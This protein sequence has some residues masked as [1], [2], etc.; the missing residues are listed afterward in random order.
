MTPLLSR[1]KKQY[2]VKRSP[3]YKLST[4][5][6]LAALLSTDVAYISAPVYSGLITQYNIFKCKQTLRFITEPRGDLRLIHKRLLKLFCRIE[7]P[8]YVHSAIKK[9]SYLTNARSHLSNLNILKIDIKKFFPSVKFHHVQN[10]FLNTL[11]CAPDVATILAK[12]CTVETK[13]H[14][15]HLPT[16]S[17]ISPIL[18]YLVNQRLFDKIASVCAAEGCIST[19]YVDDITISGKNAS[20]AL[21]TRVAILIHNAGYGYHKIKIYNAIPATVTG[22]VLSNGKLCLPHTRAKRIRQV[23]DALSCATGAYKAKFL[24]SLVGRL[25]EAEQI[26]SSFRHQRVK[27]LSEYKIEW[28]QVTAER[29]KKAKLIAKIKKSVAKYK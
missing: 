8:G 23:E 6:K 24:A 28:Q 19:V 7:T 25:S 20:K 21:L 11:C 22:V 27:V 3:L 17:C 18:S 13:L 2:D 16:G 5:R 4:K 14:G 9:R 10:F 26:D 15:I 29:A 1:P 12:L